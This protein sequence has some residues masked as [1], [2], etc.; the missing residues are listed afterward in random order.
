MTVEAF[1]DSGIFLRIYDG[2]FPRVRG[3]WENVRYL[4]PACV[5]FFKLEISIYTNLFHCDAVLGQ[6]KQV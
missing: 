1:V 3:L 2:F 6:M 5:F 4:F